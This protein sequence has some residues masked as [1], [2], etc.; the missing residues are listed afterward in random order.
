[1]YFICESLEG[2]CFYLLSMHVGMDLVPLR[3][4]GSDTSM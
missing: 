3:K 2:R 1:M 4:C